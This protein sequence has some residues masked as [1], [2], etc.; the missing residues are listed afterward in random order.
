MYR[1]HLHRADPATCA[2]L[3]AQLIA[4]GQPWVV[5]G[6]SVHADDDLLTADLAADEM[7]V[8]RRTIYA[9]RE[10]GLP[11]VATPDGPRYRVGDLHRFVADQRRQRAQ[12]R[13]RQ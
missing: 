11:V 9:W 1:H 2:S 5:P 8:A 7:R 6:A 12:R 4:M 10:R 13:K 3:D